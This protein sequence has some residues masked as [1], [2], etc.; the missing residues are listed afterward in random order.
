[1]WINSENVGSALKKFVSAYFYT[2]T[3]TGFMFCT[4]GRRRN[5]D[6]AGSP[7]VYGTLKAAATGRVKFAIFFLSLYSITPVDY[8]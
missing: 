1:M 4:L 8:H 2:H 5:V 7:C 6:N 3:Q